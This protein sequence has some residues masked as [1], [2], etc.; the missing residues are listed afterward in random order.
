[1]HLGR[2]A[3]LH[4]NYARDYDPATGR[5][6]QSDPI[7]LAGG[8]NTFSYGNANPLT[9]GDPMGLVGVPAD[10]TKISD[11]INPPPLSE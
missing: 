7:G 10:L 6:A 3:R 1:M 11:W 8:I 5:Y 2:R 9:Y 4:Y